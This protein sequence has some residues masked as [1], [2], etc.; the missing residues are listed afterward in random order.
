MCQVVV[1]PRM[2]K[3]TASSVAA[4]RTRPLCNTS[5][6]VPDALGSITALSGCPAGTFIAVGTN[7]GS[8]LVWD[9]RSD[10]AVHPWFQVCCQMYLPANNQTLI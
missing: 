2:L 5:L 1:R 7:R 8:L 3:G 4:A 6:V 9:V 10:A